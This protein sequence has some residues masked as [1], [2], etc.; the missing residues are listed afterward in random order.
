MI[1][2]PFSTA[3]I[4][5]YA[6]IGETVSEHWAEQDVVKP[7]SGVPPPP[8]SLIIPECVDLLSGMPCADGIDPALVE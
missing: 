6:G 2:R 3:Y 1:T 7:Q 5:V 8:V 4:P